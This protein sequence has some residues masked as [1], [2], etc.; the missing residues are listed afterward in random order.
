MSDALQ[1]IVEDVVAGTVTRVRGGR[2][3]FDYD[4]E[5]RE[6]SAERRCRSRCRSRSDRIPTGSRRRGCGLL[7]DNDV[8]I[9]HLAARAPARAA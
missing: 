9:Q 8:V 7:P 6:R 4:A 3:R 5:Y 2:L 1:V